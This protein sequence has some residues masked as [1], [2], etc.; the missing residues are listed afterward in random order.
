MRLQKRP[1]LLL[2]SLLRKHRLKIAFAESVTCGLLTAKMGTVHNTAEVFNGSLVCYDPVVKVA[3][4]HV[5]KTLIKKYSCESQPVTDALAKKLSGVIPADI[6]AA[7]TGL[8]S[9][10]GSE[11][12]EKP[13]GTVFY[14]VL[15]KGKI[16][17][18]KKR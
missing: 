10:G 5:S 9:P 8:A 15:W 3:V 13:V 14:S 18:E 4:L 7:V 17:R 12:E 16:Y 6:H 11:T 1:E 2:A